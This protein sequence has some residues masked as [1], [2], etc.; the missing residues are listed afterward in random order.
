[1][2]NDMFRVIERQGCLTNFK[3]CIF[4]KFKKRLE[5]RLFGIQ[6]RSTKMTNLIF[7]FHDTRSKAKNAWEL[8]SWYLCTDT[9][10]RRK[11]NLAFNCI[12]SNENEGLALA[13]HH[14][15]PKVK[16][17]CVHWIISRITNLIFSNILS[18]RKAQTWDY[19]ESSISVREHLDVSIF[20]HFVF[21][22]F[23]IKLHYLFLFFVWIFG[24]ILL[25]LKYKRKMYKFLLDGLEKE[26]IFPPQD[27]LNHFLNL[28]YWIRKKIRLFLII[29]VSTFINL[30]WLQKYINQ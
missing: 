9:K 2:E 1:M 26:D 11:H 27:R 14:G 3:K 25:T 24:L 7:L 23:R 12:I 10:G 30:H 21:A 5:T 29:F 15:T 13:F 17:Y 19:S 4:K 22:E 20:L 6:L 28:F 16:D 8:V 18:R